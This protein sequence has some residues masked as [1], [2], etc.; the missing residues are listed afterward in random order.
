MEKEKKLEYFKTLS[1]G[2]HLA[3]KAYF[4]I[5]DYCG[6][7]L[8]NFQSI[9]KLFRYKLYNNL[10]RIALFTFII[11]FIFTLDRSS[12][13]FPI[14]ITIS[15]CAL[16]AF[17]LLDF[18][19]VKDFSY[20]E[21]FYKKQKKLLN[22]N[23]ISIKILG[24]NE[25]IKKGLKLDKMTGNIKTL[26]QKI[27]DFSKH[28]KS[29]IDILEKYSI[30]VTILLAF[31]PFTT[32]ILRNPSFIS[33]LFNLLSIEDMFVIFVI[34]FSVTYLVYDTSNTRYIEKKGLLL[35]LESIFSTLI[36]VISAFLKSIEFP[37]EEVEKKDIEKDFNKL[38]KSKFYKISQMK[39]L[40]D[41]FK[42]ISEL[43]IEELKLNSKKLSNT[44]GKEETT[45]NES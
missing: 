36:F 6:L 21:N 38:K 7:D 16:I 35:Y 41:F 33:S 13:L 11:S 4:R 1:I 14:I 31:I 9:K 5:L 27:H 10:K 2:F 26:E 22:R 19:I 28:K 42:K 39:D 17:I 32:E 30:P 8:V 40:E 29:I 24:N 23:F 37:L 18:K 34:I 15:F 20:N 43:D 45:S 12:V 44:T 3:F 25:L